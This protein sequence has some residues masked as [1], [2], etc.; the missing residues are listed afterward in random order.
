M[1]RIRRTLA[2]LAMAAAVIGHASPAQAQRQPAP[3]PRA[4]TTVQLDTTAA[5]TLITPLQAEV[6]TLRIE[7]RRLKGA[8]ES[9]RLTVNANHQAYA[10]HRHAVAKYGIVT[11]KSICPDSPAID[12]TML[13]FTTAA[14][15]VKGHS[16][17]PE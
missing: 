12:G 9:L 3:P 7:V 13:A 6:E 4:G 15:P 14:G 2:P 1:H 5:Q 10:K 17:P 11:A 16:G 8:L